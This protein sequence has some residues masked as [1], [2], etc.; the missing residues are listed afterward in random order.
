M[1]DTDDDN[2]G[3]ADG[4]ELSRFWGDYWV[5]SCK[6]SCIGELIKHHGGDSQGASSA[7]AGL[8]ES[9]EAP[10]KVG[11]KSFVGSAAPA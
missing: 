10:L 8:F 7:T 3:A 5:A 11:R 4:A 1:G 2:A 9:M 6:A